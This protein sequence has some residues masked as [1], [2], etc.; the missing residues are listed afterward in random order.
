MSTWKESD[1]DFMS[2]EYFADVIWKNQLFNVPKMFDIAVLFGPFHCSLVHQIISTIF[3]VQPKYHDELTQTLPVVL[4]VFKELQQKLFKI[5]S[6][7]QQTDQSNPILLDLLFYL[8]DITSTLCAFLKVFPESSSVFTKFSFIE[9]IV[10]Y[11]ETLIPFLQSMTKN[12]SLFVRLKPIKCSML[13]IV[14]IL[15][16][17]SFLNRLDN[18]QTEPNERECISEEFYNLLSTLP[19][20]IQVEEKNDSSLVKTNKNSSDEG[21]FVKD[22]N[23]VYNLVSIITSLKTKTT[24]YFLFFLF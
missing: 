7:S 3:S 4:R 17:H 9:K 16:T 8:L 23:R 6:N 2:K 24:M 13:Q 15:I 11:Y 20:I 18:S 10:Y 12:T 1:I 22:F 5:T 21:K 19:H 14:Y